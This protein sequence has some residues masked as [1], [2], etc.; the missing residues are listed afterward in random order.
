MGWDV[1][2][3]VIQW[4][5]CSTFESLPGVLIPRNELCSCVRVVLVGGESLFFYT[6][7]SIPFPYSFSYLLSCSRLLL[8]YPPIL[9]LILS[10][11]L[12]PILPPILPPILSPYPPIISLRIFLSS[13]SS[14]RPPGA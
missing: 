1:I 5:V 6:S 13:L 7:T 2:P 9:S 10:P 11:I 4:G 8:L 12:S 3:P 14:L